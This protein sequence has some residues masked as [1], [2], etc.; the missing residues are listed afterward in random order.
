[1]ASVEILEM[2]QMM[3]KVCKISKGV[4]SALENRRSMKLEWEVCDVP[5]KMIFTGKYG[6]GGGGGVM[7]ETCNTLEGFGNMIL[8]FVCTVRLTGLLFL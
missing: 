4:F 8:S 2:T 3:S 7:R 1:M 5:M 6:G